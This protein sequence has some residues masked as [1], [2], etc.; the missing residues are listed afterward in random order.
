[1]DPKD[2]TP[3]SSG[4]AILSGVPFFGSFKG[5]LYQRII[6]GYG[7]VS[8]IQ[9]LRILWDVNYMLKSTKKR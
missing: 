6:I 3:Q 1:M 8:P 9:I 7:L 5:S 4:G 2:G